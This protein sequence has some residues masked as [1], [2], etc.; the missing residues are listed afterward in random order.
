MAWK[1]YDTLLTA[2]TG[3]AYGAIKYNIEQAQKQKENLQQYREN[4][5]AAQKYVEDYEAQQAAKTAEANRIAA[6][7]NSQKLANAS[8]TQTSQAQATAAKNVGVNKSRA[9]ALASNNTYN[10]VY[11]DSVEGLQNQNVSTQ[12]DY[13]EKLGY[14]NALNREASNLEKGAAL[15]TMGAVFQGISDEDEKENITPNRD[16]K[17][18]DIDGITSLKALGDALGEYDSD[19]VLEQLAQ[20]E[21]VSYE[22]KHPQKMGEDAEVH[23]AGFTAQSLQKIPLFKDCVIDDNGTLKINTELLENIMETV[24]LPVLKEKICN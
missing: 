4:Q 19:D 12:A 14:T 21:T 8:S 1:W 16:G 3:G 22:Y 5:E 23:P 13:L 9:G 2:A 17:L 6:E 15:N 24:V 20:L 11:L 18:N 10:N 7:Q